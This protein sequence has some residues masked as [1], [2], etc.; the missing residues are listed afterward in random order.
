MRHRDPAYW[1][2]RKPSWVL[3]LVGATATPAGGGG[4][5]AAPKTRAQ[6]MQG[7]GRI[8]EIPLL[9]VDSALTDSSGEPWGI[10]RGYSS[11]HG[12]AENIVCARRWMPRT[13]TLVS[14]SMKVLYSRVTRFPVFLPAQ[15]RACTIRWR[16]ATRILAEDA[17][18]LAMRPVGISLGRRHPAVQR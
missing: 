18:F 4:H 15:L 9:T 11:P 6:P 2:S 13:S 7:R 8:A 17:Y 1:A 16:V 14:F 10:L 12:L 5:V 3:G